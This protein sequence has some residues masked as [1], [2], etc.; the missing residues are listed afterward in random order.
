VFNSGQ[1]IFIPGFEKL[2][3]M[4]GIEILEKHLSLAILSYMFGFVLLHGATLFDYIQE[5][6]YNPCNYSDY[7][8]CR[9]YIIDRQCTAFLFLPRGGEWRCY[10]MQCRLRTLLTELQY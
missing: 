7:H 4:G 10:T 1:Y 8:K 6:I 9:L 2:A 5:K 3:E